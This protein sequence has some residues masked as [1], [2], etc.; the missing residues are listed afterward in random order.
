LDNQT[1]PAGDDRYL[2]LR[3][4]SGL[5]S[6]GRM[7]HAVVRETMRPVC[8]I[9][10]QHGWAEA[11]GDAITCPRCIATTQ[12]ARPLR[13]PT[14]RSWDRMKQRCNDPKRTEY[15]RYGGRGI[16][17]C[18]RWNESF[19]AFLADMGERPPGKT[20]DRWPNPD[21]HYE[22]GNCRW[23]TPLEQRHNQSSTPWAK[24]SDEPQRHL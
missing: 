17:V 15:P 20:L 24:V 14:Q 9:P 12:R 23:A 4:A 19:D 8:G 21:G 22:P 10:A 7:Y 3:K 13:T 18:D 6:R 11:E 5:R 1:V 2:V 16:K